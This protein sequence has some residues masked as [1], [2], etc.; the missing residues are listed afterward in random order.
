L[1]TELEQIYRQHRQSLFSVALAV[2][3]C[4]GLAE[5]A[6]HEA[7][8]RLCQ[9]S[10]SP[11]GRLVAY[12]FASVRNAA[13]DLF[14][15]QR[16]QQML[17]ESLFAAG[18]GE[19]AAVDSPGVTANAERGE[20]EIAL[21]NAIDA[22]DEVTRQIVIMKIYAELTFEDIGEV[23]AMPSATV[24]TRYRRAIMKL[25]EQLRRDG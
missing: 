1:R 12:V 2:T 13:V 24:A 11:T 25:E 7:F 14:R 21:K 5:D 4:S 20:Q 6:V 9:K 22:L 17:A 19:S 15:R 18:S 10:E 23:V 3:G 8:A 16:H